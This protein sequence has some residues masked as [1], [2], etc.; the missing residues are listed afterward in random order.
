VVAW[1]AVVVDD[2]EN[3]PLIIG[4]ILPRCQ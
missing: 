1:G 4:P 3:S 2:F